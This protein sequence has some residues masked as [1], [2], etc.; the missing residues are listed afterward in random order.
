MTER[1]LPQRVVHGFEPV[2]NE[3]SRVL[4]LGTMPSPKSRE[5]GFYYGH[6]R[7]RFWPVLSQV[8]GEECPGTAE[9]R[10]GARSAAGLLLHAWREGVDHPVTG[11]RLRLETAWPTRLWPTCPPAL[12]DR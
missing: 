1:S 2:W 11:E 12:L 6:P 3:Q 9:G 7:N 10:R 8:L 5:Q 4:I